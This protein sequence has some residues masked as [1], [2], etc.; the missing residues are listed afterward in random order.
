M[1]TAGRRSQPGSALP[2]PPAQPSAR[3]RHAARRPGLGARQLLRRG[4]ARRGAP[5]VRR[6]ER[7]PRRPRGAPAAPGPRGP[8]HHHRR[9][10]WLAG[11]RRL[12]GGHRVLRLRLAV[13]HPHLRLQLPGA[14]LG[15]RLDGRG[16]PALRGDLAGPGP[17]PAALPGDGP[18][19]PLAPRPARLPDPPRAHRLRHVDWLPR[20]DHGHAPAGP[21]QRRLGDRGRRA[22]G[23]R[24]PRLG[25]RPGPRGLPGRHEPRDPHPP[26]RRARHDRG[27]LGSGPGR[28]AGGHR[29]HGPQL[30]NR[31]APPAGRGPGLLQDRGRQAG[32]GGRPHAARRARPRAHR[33]PPRSGPGQGPPGAGGAA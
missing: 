17:G 23:R 10:A 2:G 32:A 3:R 25:L 30:R 16:H 20:P 18:R 29:P 15:R 28:Q 4:V 21:A 24:A 31:A 11:R 9:H 22:P 12:T 26:Q 1:A 13:G 5:A 6:L 14:P 27:A 8:P 19:A 7:R 33:G